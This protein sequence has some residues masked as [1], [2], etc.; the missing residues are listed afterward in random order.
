MLM[1]A[2]LK[3]FTC[4]VLIFMLAALYLASCGEVNSDESIVSENGSQA[5]SN[6]VN[7]SDESSEESSEDDYYG[8]NLEVRDLGGRIINVLCRDWGGNSIQ[9]YNGEI[10]QRE[11]FDEK[12]ADSVDVS[13]YEVRRLIESRYNCIIKGSLETIAPAEFNNKVRNM[14][15]GGTQDF[16]IVFDAY[17][18][19][20]ALVTE[21]IYI[22]L[23]S[24]ESIDF[25]NPW[26]DQNAVND[27]SICNKLFFAC[28]DINT[29][30]NDGTWVLYY[31]KELLA[32]A[33]P[34]VD[35]Y[36]MVDNNTWTFD[37]F[38]EICKSVSADTDGVDGMNEFDTWGLGTETYNVYVHVIASGQRICE[39][40]G[41]GEP[42]FTYQTESMYTVLSD[43]L[44]LYLDEDNVM[45]AN[46]GKYNKY[47]NVWE[48][49]II[50]AF[51]EGRELFYMGGLINAV[52]Y[53]ELEF[54]YGILPIPKYSSA[55]DHYYHSVSFHN[56]S[57][58]MIPT[59]ASAEDNY[60]LGLV[61][62]AL[63]AESKN[64]LTPVYYE[65]ALKAK[66]ADTEDDERML[67]IIF[68]SRCFDLGAAF[69]WGNIISQFMT[70]DVNY[71]SRFETTA[72]VV[73]Q[74][75]EDTIQ[76]IKDNN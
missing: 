29:Y 68:G 72:G 76:A 9:G 15:N 32:K 42:I 59:G 22:D 67:D 56:M 57:C 46:G 55:Q 48:D 54:P 30:D 3:R 69:N 25:N 27:L 60:D 58:M 17:G 20:N 21:G 38:A 26:W 5:I 14:V 66:N 52:S 62:E 71:T 12:N 34:D 2:T 11:D 13:K 7:L 39:K 53:R 10:I 43:V 73:Q 4:F 36:E 74:A 24:I 51:R 64:Y 35:P 18:Y 16:D 47:P 61:I 40:D 19:S 1:K 41:N 63:G 49:T 28:G 75:M 8:T 23:F 31:N 33:L 44:E 70:L 65:K 50:K 37:K 45:V 6:D